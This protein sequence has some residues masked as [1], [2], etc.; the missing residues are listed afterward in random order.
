MALVAAVIALALI[1]FLVHGLR[2]VFP[3]APGPLVRGLPYA[4]S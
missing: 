4:I 1:E 2:Y 3:V